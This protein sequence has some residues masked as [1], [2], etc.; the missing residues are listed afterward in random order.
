MPREVVHIQVGQCGNSIGCKFW[1]TINQEHGLSP[2]GTFTGND[3]IQL[4]KIDVFYHETD[5]GRYVPRACLVDM[6]NSVLNHVT[7]RTYGGMFRPQNLISST[8]GAANNFMNGYYSETALSISDIVVD[9]LR[10]EVERTECCQGFTFSHSTAGG[11]GSGLTMRIW[12]EA[13]S[14]LV[15]SFGGSYFFSVFPGAKVSNTV[16]EPYNTMCVLEKQSQVENVVCFD[17]E[18]L[19]EICFNTLGLVSPTFSDLNRLVS[20]VMSGNTAS[21]RFPGQVNTDMNKLSYALKCRPF[22]HWYIPAFAPLTSKKTQKYRKITVSELVRQMTAEHNQMFGTLT[23]PEDMAANEDQQDI[24]GKCFAYAAMFRGKMSSQAVDEALSFLRGDQMLENNLRNTIGYDGRENFIL[25]SVKMCQKYHP[26]NPRPTFNSITNYAPPGMPMSVTYLRNSSNVKNKF[27]KLLR[28]AM[29]MYSTNSFVGWYDE[30]NYTSK[31]FTSLDKV[32]KTMS[33]EWIS[34]FGVEDQTHFPGELTE[35][36]IRT[37]M[38]GGP[39]PSGNKTDRVPAKSEPAPE[40]PAAAP[41][42]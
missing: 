17:N 39:V 27:V 5:H 38:I 26:R 32:L 3:P 1:E 24:E 25:E 40:A 35:D 2:N 21:F 10:R 14:L 6:E 7:Q 41:Q 42:E 36:D 33:T 16:L 13:A 37:M 9:C 12:N 19:Y 11:T 18:A 29:C 4:E 28:K 8:I 31:D 23:N 30:Q 22:L 34:E 15:P 20:M